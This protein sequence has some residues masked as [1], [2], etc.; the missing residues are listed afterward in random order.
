M[1]HLRGR[2]TR[3]NGVPVEQVEI[4]PEAQ[5]AVRNE[6][7]LTYSATPPDG[8]RLTAGA[9]WP[10]DYEG[11]LAISL[12]ANLARGFGVGVGATMSFHVLWRELAG[13][14]AHPPDTQ[15]GHLP[16]PF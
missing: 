16:P 9:W 11:P 12:A 15:M 2:I 10:A 1:P 13:R 8:T 14:L 3:L 5:W 4:A 7:G 6:R